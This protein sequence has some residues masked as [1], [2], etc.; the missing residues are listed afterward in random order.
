MCREKCQPVLIFGNGLNKAARRPFE[1]ERVADRELRHWQV[2]RIGICRYD[3]L[4]QQSA[5][6]E[7]L[8][9]HLA[10]GNDKE[11][12]VT[13][14]RNGSDQLVILVVAAAAKDTEK[15][16]LLFYLARF[17]DGRFGSGASCRGISQ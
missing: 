1:I 2:R 5:N 14:G 6:V 13:A 12:A 15:L 4:K 16:F 9:P 10:G 17:T 8:F 7:I 3:R 11:L